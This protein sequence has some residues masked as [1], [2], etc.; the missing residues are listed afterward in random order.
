MGNLIQSTAFSAKPLILG[1]FP[2]RN[3]KQTFRLFT[4]LAKFLST[5]LNRE[6]RLTTA[7]NFADFWEGVKTQRYDI[8]HFNQYHYI[9]AKELYGYEVILKNQE[10]GNSTVAGTITIRKDSGI[11][12]I[13]DLKGKTILFGGGKRAMQSYISAKW[14]LQQGG[15]NDGDYIE[16]FAI[17]PPNAIISTYL[18]QA[19]AAGCGDVIIRLDTVKAHIDVSKMQ[20]LARTEQLPHLPWAVKTSMD[21]VTR[22]KIQ[23]SLNRLNKDPAGQAILDRA[24]L[25]ALNLAVDSDYDGHRRIIR[26]VYGDDYGVEYLK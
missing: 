24:Q 6:V 18:K 7:K 23:H 13:K 1:V 2:R 9:V 4:P 14:L 20:Y 17:N 12:S 16:K 11:R 26:D 22:L 25:S 3:T 19:D 15:L 5:T 21:E 8:V 10:F